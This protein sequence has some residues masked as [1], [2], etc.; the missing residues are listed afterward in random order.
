M[1]WR[2]VKVMVVVRDPTAFCALIV[3]CRLFTDC[4]GVPEMIPLLEFTVNPL[5]SE[6][7]AME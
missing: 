7:E 4:D 5:G 2:T 1:D 3:T 6:P